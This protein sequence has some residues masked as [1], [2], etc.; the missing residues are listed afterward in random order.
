MTNNEK[1]IAVLERRAE[2]YQRANQEKRAGGPAT[3]ASI[4]RWDY[5]DDEK[6]SGVQAGHVEMVAAEAEKVLD[7][8]TSLSKQ[9]YVPSVYLA[10]AFVGLGEKDKAFEWLEKAYEDRSV[11][12]RAFISVDPIFDPLRSYPRFA[13]LLRRMNLQP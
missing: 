5:C 11:G 9:K 7:Q 3:G 12:T 8:L 2:I 6:Q 13:D 4:R 10:E 1:R